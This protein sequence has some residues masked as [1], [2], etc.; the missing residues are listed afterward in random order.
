MAVDM[1]RAFT[2]AADMKGYAEQLKAVRRQLVLEKSTLTRSW[3]GREVTYMVR[4]IDKSIARID[5]LIRLL[6]Q[7]GNKIKYNAEHIEVQESSVKGG[8]SR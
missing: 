8:G 3:Q 4:S 6:N 2:Q 1:H 5:K 7:A